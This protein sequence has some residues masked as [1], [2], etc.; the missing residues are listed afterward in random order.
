MLVIEI[1]DLSCC[2]PASLHF[3]MGPGGMV[4]FGHAAFSAAAPMA[5]L[6]LLHLKYA[7][8]PM[9]VALLFAALAGAALAILFGWFCVRLSG[10]YLAMLTRSPSPRSPGRSCS[11][12]ATFTGGDDGILGTWPSRLGE[13]PHGLLLLPRW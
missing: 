11:S 4:S 7:E 10:V 6:A 12:G 3:I 9:E 1:Y 13:Q 8:A 5:R 2:S